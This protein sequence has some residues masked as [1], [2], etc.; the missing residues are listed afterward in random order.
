VKVK[1]RRKE[2]GGRRK[3]EEGGRRKKFDQVRLLSSHP[4]FSSVGRIWDT[5]RNGRARRSS[6]CGSGIKW[7]HA[8]EVA[9]AAVALKLFSADVVIFERLHC[10]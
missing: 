10:F 2:E 9:I 5:A 7:L 8:V 4:L 3:E 6:R 1:I